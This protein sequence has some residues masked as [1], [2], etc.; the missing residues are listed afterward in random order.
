MNA[1]IDVSTA[2]VPTADEAEDLFAQVDQHVGGGELSQELRTEIIGRWGSVQT[3]EGE[4]QW[5]LVDIV[6][7]DLSREV[8][9]R[10]SPEVDLRYCVD[11]TGWLPV[12]ASGE[13]VDRPGE[14]RVWATVAVWSDDWFGQN[15]EDW[16]IRQLDERD[17]PC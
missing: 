17:D 2:D 5:D 1:Y 12:D 3:V 6:N 9:G 14:R 11:A 8:D 10:S 4:L 15:I 16:R 13:P 7:V